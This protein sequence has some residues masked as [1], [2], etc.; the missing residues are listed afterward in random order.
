MTFAKLLGRFIYYQP[1]PTAKSST[2][3]AFGRI[4]AKNLILRNLCLRF[5]FT[6]I[7]AAL[8]ADI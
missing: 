5:G 7:F 2:G 4:W 8:F 6:S 1:S 3:P